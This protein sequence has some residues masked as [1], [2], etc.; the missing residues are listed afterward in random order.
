[1]DDVSFPDDDPVLD[2]LSAAFPRAVITGYA[3]I[4][5]YIDDEGEDQLAF[6]GLPNQRATTTIGLL[7]AAL[8]IEKSKFR[9]DG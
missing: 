2:V 6:S 1:M 3:L 4:V 9:L 5:N 8:E 7:T